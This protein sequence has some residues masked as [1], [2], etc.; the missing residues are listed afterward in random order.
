[1]RALRTEATRARERRWASLGASVVLHLCGLLLGAVTWPDP[2][3]RP[4]PEV[5]ELALVAKGSKDV[6]SAPPS[7]APKRDTPRRPAP[8]PTPAPP[9]PSGEVAPD[10]PVEEPSPPQSFAEWQKERR[11]R[12]MPAKADYEAGRI[13]GR[14]AIHRP[15]RRSCDPPEARGAERV[16]LLFDSSGSMTGLGRMQALQCAQQY[17][18]G[19]LSNGAEVVVANFARDVKFSE[20]TRDMLDVQIALRALTDPTQTRL[21]SRELQRFFQQ[22]PDAPADLVIIS[23]GW[24]MTEREVLIWYRFFLDLHPENRGV[25]YTVG[26]RGAREAVTQLRGLG[27]DVHAYEPTAGE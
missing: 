26:N 21:P 11:S 9:A 5:V 10:D 19:A 12:Y 2:P 24:F 6:E 4:P 7:S 14:A 18:S 1:L 25:M 20:P 8:S 16:Y 17:A 27:F 3:E 15:G 23:D 22:V 13:D